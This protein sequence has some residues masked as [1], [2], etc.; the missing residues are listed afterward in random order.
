MRLSNVK[1]SYAGPD[2]NVIDKSLF[3]WFNQ[4][5]I[6]MMTLKQTSVVVHTTAIVQMRRPGNYIF[7]ENLGS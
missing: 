7:R 2:S 1:I 4:V 5:L 6:Y 3:L